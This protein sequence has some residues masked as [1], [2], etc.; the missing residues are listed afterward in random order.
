MVRS[1]TIRFSFIFLLAFFSFLT[2]PTEAK[3]VVQ[4]INNATG[5]NQ[6]ILGDSNV[7]FSTNT[8]TSIHTLGWSGFLPI[9]RGGTGAPS[10]TNGS[11][12]FISGGIFSQNNSNF[13]WDSTNN[14]LGIGTNSPSTTLTVSGTTTTT[15]L[16]TTS[17]STINT[18]K[19]GLGGGNVSTNTMVGSNALSSNTTGI[20]NV[21]IGKNA[22][23]SNTEQS[24]ST[25]IGSDALAN[26][27]GGEG[28]NTAVGVGTLS[29]ANMSGSQN[30]AFGSSA[31]TTNTSGANNT[32]IGR[33]SMSTNT[34]GSQNTALGTSSLGS[35]T[36]G[37]GN[38]VLGETAFLNNLTGGL[39]VVI[40]HEAARYQAEGSNLT[41]ASNSIYI[42]SLTRGYDNNDTNSIVIG[43][44]A[45]GAGANKTIIGNSSMTDVYFGS[46]DGNASTH[47]K[48]MF[49]GSS[50]VPGCIVMG[51][52]TGGVGYITLVSGALTVSSSP[53][54]ACQ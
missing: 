15:S 31:L 43:T 40:G 19:V 21:A 24:G 50:S 45:I 54:S 18:I 33:A 52:T 1:T 4:N 27:S 22:L 48:K 39:N 51:D 8:G 26:T 13:F 3:A 6:T 10:F 29:A 32:A 17:D 38:V 34:T 14:R 11:V 35:N 28:N 30:S 49:L 25:A 41:T 37:N 44:N 2:I 36:T 7:T 12:P 53:P 9:S 5:Q 20:H 46:A 16:T 23:S 42:G 47:A